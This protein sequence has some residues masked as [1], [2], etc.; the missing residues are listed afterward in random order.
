MKALF[1]GL[2]AAVASYSSTIYAAAI[3]VAP[4][5]EILLNVAAGESKD[6]SSITGLEISLN[7]RSDE[8]NTFWGFHGAIQNQKYGTF[9]DSRFGF[10]ASFNYQT[11]LDSKLN[12]G[13]KQVFYSGMGQTQKALD[14]LNCSNV[15]QNYSG[16]QTFLTAGM[17]TDSN[18]SFRVDM[19]ISDNRSNASTSA[20]DPWHVG[21]SYS[22]SYRG[23]PDPAII[24]NVGK[25]W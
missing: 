21:P 1:L 20:S 16:G 11:E 23:I 12:F 14:C 13:V 24:L 3:N 25:S 22:S 8:S 5:G 18:W 2:M 17:R 4:K 9:N 7:N 6:T 19:R 15:N 10:G